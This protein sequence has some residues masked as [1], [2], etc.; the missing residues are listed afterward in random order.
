MTHPSENPLKRFIREI[1]R[2]SLW[3]VLGI[4]VVSGWIVYEAVQSL[5]EGLGLPAWFP[6]LAFIF[7]V[8]GLPIVLAT[9][10]AQASGSHEPPSEASGL[11][12]GVG[13]GASVESSVPSRVF[14]W[15]NAVLGGVG[16]F[17]LVGGVGLGWL[18]F[19]E[20][21]GWTAS[22]A[23]DAATALDGAPTSIER[24][25]AV[26]PFDDL[27]PEGD[28]R[29]F[30]E[31]LSEEII[32]ALAQIPGLEVAAR[33]STFLL[34]ER[35][36]DGIIHAARA[37]ELDPVSRVS[38]AILGQA[39]MVA[40]RMEEAIE[41]FRE[42]VA[43]APEWVTGWAEL[44]LAVGR[45]GDSDEALKA[46]LTFARLG[47]R[48]PQLAQIEF[49]GSALFR[50]TGQPRSRADEIIGR[51]ENKVRAGAFGWAA[52]EYVLTYAAP[53]DDDPRYQDLLAEAG[54]TW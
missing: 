4:Y 41:Q 39:L 12:V 51:F 36:T 38:S 47:D 8:L 37:V 23:F 20:A 45:I 27:S 11:I 42:T 5:T 33:T 13:S 17:V 46:Y 21:G 31:G 52:Q 25:I 35:G 44:S 50:E 53:L 24:S 7:L 3:Q 49:E 1:H 26:L 28:E 15:R 34:A 2:R 18:M 9:A 48:D 6:P 19:G 29:Y 10:F 54:I 30:V 43:L 14:T 40:G 22:T 16:A 32:H